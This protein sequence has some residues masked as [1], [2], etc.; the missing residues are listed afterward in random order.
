MFYSIF[1]TFVVLQK[2]HGLYCLHETR[3]ELSLVVMVI[4]CATYQTKLW[5]Q[6]AEFVIKMSGKAHLCFTCRLQMVC[7]N[8]APKLKLKSE[9]FSSTVLTLFSLSF[10]LLYSL[11]H[12][13]HKKRLEQLYLNF[14]HDYLM[15][16]YISV[17]QC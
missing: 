14:F 11:I 16:E 17:S 6:N 13:C 9:C 7:S 1:A 3:T 15:K 2:K 10:A 5:Q 4:I 8:N 12:T